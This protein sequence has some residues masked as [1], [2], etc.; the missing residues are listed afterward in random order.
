[1]TSVTSDDTIRGAVLF[2]AS[3][4]DEKFDF[5]R[6]ADFDEVMAADNDKVV[7]GDSVEEIGQQIAGRYLCE[8]GC[9]RLQGTS[10]DFKAIDEESDNGYGLRR[11]RRRHRSYDRYDDSVKGWKVLPYLKITEPQNRD[12]LKVLS[13]THGYL[14]IDSDGF[15]HLGGEQGLRAEGFVTAG[16]CGH[17]RIRWNPTN[18]IRL[19]KPP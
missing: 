4:I 3:E 13:Q 1:M 17:F 6:L 15:H 2:T 11:R 9:T 8:A 12:Q 14:L 5:W 10:E 18:A 7:F 16:E 19:R